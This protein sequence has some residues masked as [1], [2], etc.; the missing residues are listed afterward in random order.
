M[1]PVHTIPSYFS[2]ARFNIILPPPLRLVLSGLF[3]SGFPTIILHAFLLSPIRTACPAHL[4]LLNL[5]I[6]IILGEQHKL[7]GSSLCSF[8]QTLFSPLLVPIFSFITLFSNSLSLCYSL[9]FR[10]QVY[11]I[12]GKIIVLYIKLNYIYIHI[13]TSWIQHAR[14]T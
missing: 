12:T 2:K 3:P 11:K 14:V 7:R 4:I 1:N 8:Q 10:D 6:L 5:I 13:T 9:S